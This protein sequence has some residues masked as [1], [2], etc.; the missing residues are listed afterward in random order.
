MT[1][2]ERELAFTQITD[3]ATEDAKQ[4]ILA[5]AMRMKG[6]DRVGV[7]IIA[8]MNVMESALLATTKP[9]RG[10]PD[11]ALAQMVLDMMAVEFDDII[12]DLK[13]IAGRA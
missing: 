9:S 13:R 3:E 12:A 6:R 7:V 8:S 5:H 10:D 11:P 1:E 4:A 2:E